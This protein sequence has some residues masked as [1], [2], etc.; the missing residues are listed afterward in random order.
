MS[1]DSGKTIA[2]HLDI[3]GTAV[4]IDNPAASPQEMIERYGFHPAQIVQNADGS[5][6]WSVTDLVRDVWFK[7]MWFAHS[8]TDEQRRQ[9]FAEGDW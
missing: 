7:A 9:W 8:L 6:V 2:K 3:D 1:D 5:D 4:V